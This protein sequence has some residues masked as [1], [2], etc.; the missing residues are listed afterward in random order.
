MELKITIPIHLTAFNQESLNQL[1]E[2]NIKYLKENPD[3][4]L[5][6]LGKILKDRKYNIEITSTSVDN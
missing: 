1:I 3:N 4:L 2:I 6:Y 5:K